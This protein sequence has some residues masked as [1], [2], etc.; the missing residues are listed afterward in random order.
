MILWAYLGN[1]KTETALR[2]AIKM[3]IDL[4]PHIMDQWSIGSQNY[5][6]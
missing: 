2:K 1:L 6:F 5:E 4:H 3:L